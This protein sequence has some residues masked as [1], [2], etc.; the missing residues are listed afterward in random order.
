MTFEILTP[1][2]LHAPIYGSII[3]CG[4]FGIADDFTENYLSLD[5]KYLSNR[6]STFLVRAGGDSMEPEIKAGDI[7]IVDRSVPLTSGKIATFYF[8]GNA[9]CKQ[10]IKRAGKIFLHSYNLNYQDIEVKDTDDLQLFGV[11]T[12]ITRDL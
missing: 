6:E 7:L 3:S 11:V 12:G 2:T 1:K 10:Y 5:E 8:N 4:L 9:I